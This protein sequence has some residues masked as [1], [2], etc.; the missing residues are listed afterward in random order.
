MRHCAGKYRVYFRPLLVLAAATL[1]V[2]GR[3]LGH[4]FIFNWDD[5][6]Y[7]VENRAIQGFSWP[8]LREIFT[9]CYVGD[10]A[11]VQMLSYTLDHAL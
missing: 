11:P 9:T 8:H 2:Y 5:A 3:I 6:R 7:V 10:Y 4:D 1:A